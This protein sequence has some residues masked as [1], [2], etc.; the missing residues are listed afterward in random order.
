MKY[1]IKWTSRFKKDYQSMMKRGFDLS[2]LDA[3]IEKL[4]NGEA[5]PSENH[6][7]A[8]VGKYA[9]LRE[10]HLKPDWLLIY[11]IYEEV[12]VLSLARTGSHSDLF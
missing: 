11:G 10:C 7:H 6:D 5:L 8:L 1:Q 9:A 3:V 12:L 4:A 2:R